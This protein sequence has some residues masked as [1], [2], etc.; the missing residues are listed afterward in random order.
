MVGTSSPQPIACVLDS[1]LKR[2]VASKSKLLTQR[3]LQLGRI[4]DPYAVKMLEHR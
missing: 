1:G 3:D 2:P 4:L